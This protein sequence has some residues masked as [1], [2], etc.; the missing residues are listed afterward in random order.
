[1]RRGLQSYSVALYG[2]ELDG[3]ASP[4]DTLLIDINRGRV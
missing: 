2:Y 1:M 4:R 3:T